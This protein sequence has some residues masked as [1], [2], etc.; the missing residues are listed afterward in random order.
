LR[1]VSEGEQ[2]LRGG[3]Q[4]E[5][6]HAAPLRE[7]EG[8]E[9]SR[10][11]EDDMEVVGVEDPGHALRDPACLCQALTLRAVPIATRVIGGALEAAR[12]THVDVAAESRR[13]T[14]GDGAQRLPLLA[15]EEVLTAAAAQ[16][17]RSTSR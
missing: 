15:G 16:R 17:L 9:G 3:A 10:E 8:P 6:E 1:I 2:G 7:G 13:P 4:Q 14:D 12:P 11:R 5:G